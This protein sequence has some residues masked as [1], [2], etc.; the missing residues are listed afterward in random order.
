GRKP[1]CEQHLDRADRGRRSAADDTEREGFFTGMV[2]GRQDNCVFVVEERGFAG[3][4]AFHGR[5]RSARTDPYFHGR[6]YGEMVA[7]RKDD[8]VHLVCLSRLQGRRLQQE[9]GRSQREGQGEGAGVRTTAVPSLDALV[10]REAFAPVRDAS[11]WK[12]R[13]K[14]FDPGCELR[15]TSG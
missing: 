14:G 12:R 11:G 3:V 1:E 7:R 2:T 9:E 10:R 4:P 5:R 15:R 8:C 6:G 13:G